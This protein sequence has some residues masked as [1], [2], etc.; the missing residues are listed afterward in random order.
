MKATR[1]SLYAGIEAAKPGA[2]L[3]QVASA[4]EQTVKP[5]GYGIVREFGGHGFGEKL[6]VDSQAPNDEA[7]APNRVLRPGR[8]PA[9]ESMINAGKPVVR[10]LDDKWTAVTVDGKLSAQYGHTIAITAN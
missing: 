5:L 10:V 4:I 3:R 1:D 8:T 9:L 7:A 6:Q 2:T